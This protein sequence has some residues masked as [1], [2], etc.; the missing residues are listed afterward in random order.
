[1]YSSAVERLTADQ[2]V[3]GSN[4]GAPCIDVKG[5]SS[6]SASLTNCLHALQSV[7]G[8][9]GH[10]SVGRAFDCRICGYRMVPGSIPGVRTFCIAVAQR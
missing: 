1:M 7:A 2:Q 6:A 8:V 4:P 9:T 10:S 3:P 5:A